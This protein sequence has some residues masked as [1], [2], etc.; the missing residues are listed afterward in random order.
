MRFDYRRLS[1]ALVAAVAFAA[2]GCRPGTPRSA[3]TDSARSAAGGDS[4]ARSGQPNMTQADSIVLRTDKTQYRP[5]EAMTLTL[6]NKGSAHYTFN[7]C[8]RSLERAMEIVRSILGPVRAAAWVAVAMT[9]LVL[10]GVIAHNLRLR[11]REIEIE[12]LLGADAALIRR[13]ITTE[14]LVL[15]T[16]A[17]IFGAGFSIVMTLIVTIRILD[18]KPQIDLGAFVISV[19]GTILVTGV[20]ANL[21]A[22][23]VLGLRGTTGK[24]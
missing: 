6:E 11:T 7:P 12:K 1:T 15:A 16:V 20:I 22:R 9:F 4:S 10:L 14:Y 19:C 8:S 3:T 18:L 2:P 24:L 21:S 23:R 17:S 13:L 5:G